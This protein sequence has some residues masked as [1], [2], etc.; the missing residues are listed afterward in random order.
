MEIAFFLGGM[1]R[2]ASDQCQSSLQSGSLAIDASISAS[3]SLRSVAQSV[4][5]FFRGASRE[6]IVIFFSFISSR[7]SC[8]YYPTQVT[9]KCTYDDDF[10]VIE[11]SE[12]HVAC[13]LYTSPSPRDRTRSR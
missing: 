1:T 4:L 13:L 7:S 5:P 6:T 8:R 2:T 9:P 12:H 3:V 10:N 11:K